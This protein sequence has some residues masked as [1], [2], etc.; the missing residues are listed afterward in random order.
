MRT[1]TNQTT[2]V[3]CLMTAWYRTHANLD[4]PYGLVFAVSC[5][6]YHCS[7]YHNDLL[8][9][10]LQAGYSPPLEAAAMQGSGLLLS[11]YQYG[12]LLFTSAASHTLDFLAVPDITSL[13]QFSRKLLTIE[14]AVATADSAP[15]EHTMFALQCNYLPSP[16]HTI[17]HPWFLQGHCMCPTHTTPEPAHRSCAFLSRL[18]A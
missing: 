14:K 16:Q 12:S 11:P 6:Y 9:Q 8:L 17:M 3:S 1:D 15:G 10:P 4:D 13:C 7:Y 5:A 18:T 2:G